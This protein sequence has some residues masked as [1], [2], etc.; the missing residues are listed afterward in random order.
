LGVAIDQ[1]IDASVI[2][3]DSNAASDPTAGSAHAERIVKPRPRAT[4][5]RMFVDGVSIT[6]LSVSPPSANARSIRRITM[7]KLSGRIIG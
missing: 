2:G 6:M 3:I 5:G 7:V 4:S 1:V